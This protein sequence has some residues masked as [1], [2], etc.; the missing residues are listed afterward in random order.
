MD[1]ANSQQEENQ[2]MYTVSLPRNVFQFSI[3]RKGKRGKIKFAV[4]L[5][6]EFEAS[7][8]K[9]EKILQVSVTNVLFYQ[10]KTSLSI[11]SCSCDF[12]FPNIRLEGSL[13]TFQRF[14]HLFLSVA[15]C[16]LK[17]M[18]RE[19]TWTRIDSI[20]LRKFRPTKVLR[21][22]TKLHIR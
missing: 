16:P 4:H 8:G 19:G 13:A 17:G 10:A 14:W 21:K 9:V 11:L 5:G 7:L 1:E 18:A 22:S 12:M 20:I 6:I 3:L 2:V 15:H